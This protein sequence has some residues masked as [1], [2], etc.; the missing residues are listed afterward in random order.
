MTHKLW[1][2]ARG[3]YILKSFGIRIF[4]RTN[5]LTNIRTVHIKFV[6]NCLQTEFL[7]VNDFSKR[8]FTDNRFL[9]SPTLKK[10]SLNVRTV[11]FNLF[12]LF[13]LHFNVWRKIKCTSSVPMIYWIKIHINWKLA[14]TGS[15]L[16]TKSLCS[17]VVVCSYKVLVKQIYYEK[18]YSHQHKLVSCMYTL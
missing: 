7:F 11:Y 14:L 4:S 6:K 1:Q 2:S 5:L 17:I 18:N 8:S 3:S 13:L 16:V 9:I 15:T 10:T 12:A